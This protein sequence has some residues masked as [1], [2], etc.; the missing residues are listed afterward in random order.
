MNNENKIM[1][2]PSVIEQAICDKLSQLNK[3][4]KFYEEPLK[5]LKEQ[6][7]ELLKWCKDNGMTML[8]EQ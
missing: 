7:T 5:K 3:D 4:I 1:P 8:G 6:K 2:A